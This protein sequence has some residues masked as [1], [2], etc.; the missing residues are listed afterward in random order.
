M[1][2]AFYFLFLVLITQQAVNAIDFDGRVIS[3]KTARRFN[4]HISC[5]PDG[6]YN[7]TQCRNN[8]CSCVNGTTRVPISGSLSFRVGSKP[9]NYCKKLIAC[10]PWNCKLFCL[11]GYTTD[12]QG[13]RQCSC[14]QVRCDYTSIKTAIKRCGVGCV[15]YNGICISCI[16]GCN[17]TNI[18][19]P[20]SCGSDEEYVRYGF[21]R[22]ACRPKLRR[23]DTCVRDDDNDDDDDYDDDHEQ[24]DDRDDDH[25]NDHDGSNQDGDEDDYVSD[26]I[27]PVEL[28]LASSTEEDMME[29]DEDDKISRIFTGS[30]SRRASRKINRYINRC[31]NG[32]YCR[33]IRDGSR[34]RCYQQN[35]NGICYKNSNTP[36]ECDS[37][38]YYKP[39]YCRVVTVNNRRRIIC[40]C[41]IPSNGT[42]LNDTRTTFEDTGNEEENEN[43]KP[44]CRERVYGTCRVTR[45]GRRFLVK[46]GEHDTNP[47]MCRTCVCYFGTLY[48]R[49]RRNCRRCD[50]TKTCTLPNN[51][52]IRHGQSARVDCNRCS[53]RYG[54][55]YCTD[56]DCNTTVTTETNCTRCRSEGVS[57]VCG[58]NGKTYIN[59]CTAIYCAGIASVDLI[60]GPCPRTNPCIRF[61][62]DSGQVCLKRGGVSCLSRDTGCRPDTLRHCISVEDL[63]CTNE[64]ATR[65][66]TDDDD[67]D[68]SDTDGDGI[69]NG[70]VDPDDTSICGTDGNT[71]ASICHM[72]QSTVNVTILYAG[73]CNASRC[74]GGQV[75]GT[76]G[77]TYENIC[78]L[79]TQSN[80]ARFDYRGACVDD[81]DETAGQM[82]QRV[83]SSGRCRFN[84]SNCPCLVRPTV[85]CCPL[86]GGAILALLDREGISNASLLDPDL[87]TLDGYVR[88]I[89]S[90]ELFLNVTAGR[91]S[92]ESSLTTAGNIELAI[93]S[94]SNRSNDRC[95][96]HH[97]AT[98]IT[99]AI[100]RSV[101]EQSRKRRQATTNTDTSLSPSYQY[102][103]GASEAQLETSTGG[104]GTESTGTT[105]TPTS[106]G[107]TATFAFMTV[108]LLTVLAIVI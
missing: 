20:T 7:I 37:N 61:P 70:D 104:P 68:D 72:L 44:R 13:C 101:E 31:R 69:G 16:Q 4:R 56:R 80:N 58:P 47:C 102:I 87:E 57:R 65:T 42:R 38:G 26:D 75:C 92:V 51:T 77:V 82:C 29:K 83:I 66:S 78:E 84:T 34:G 79:R 8:Y 28:E 12:D 48:C 17:S 63:S 86:C 98:N 91:C 25:D 59:S 67:D 64:T 81:S 10:G 1:L 89:V 85:G 54:N 52:V 27:P 19:I 100:N 99:I 40:V 30:S 5:L 3:C 22:G 88:Q 62:C 49:T 15:T 46:H 32:Y 55:L 39:R 43:R 96:C 23:N 76:D 90:D 105:A 53:C 107:V 74:K 108:L 36:E 60:D 6:S 24:D 21:G 71:Y 2:K 9:S 94:L 73:H 11:R 103:L 14:K 93:S 97:V 95:Y 41:V 45:G 50:L 33:K 35:T 106:S 18:T